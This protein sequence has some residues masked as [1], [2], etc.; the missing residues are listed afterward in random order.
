MILILGEKPS[1]AHDIARP[2]PGR[3]EAMPT[4]STRALR[5]SP[6]RNKPGSLSA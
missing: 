3:S 6:T 1:V 2:R 4:L 5:H